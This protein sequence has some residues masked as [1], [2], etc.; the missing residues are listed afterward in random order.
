MIEA[1]SKDLKMR[2]RRLTYGIQKKI[3]LSNLLSCIIPTAAIGIIVLSIAGT[4]MREQLYIN[5]QSF[6]Q[7]LYNTIDNNFYEVFTS[8]YKFTR[9][10]DVNSFIYNDYL[11]VFDKIVSNG[12]LL[13][14]MTDFQTLKSDSDVVL[15]SGT[16][17]IKS[18]DKINI[19]SIDEIKNC[20][21]FEKLR[22]SKDY[23]DLIWNFPTGTANGMYAFAKL[24]NVPGSD[25]PGVVAIGQSYKYFDDILENT[26]FSSSFDAIIIFDGD[27]SIVYSSEKNEGIL[28]DLA[29]KGMD[30]IKQS[31]DKHRQLII[32]DEKYISIL[33]TSPKYKWSIL[34]LTSEKKVSGRLNNVNKYILLITAAFVVIVFVLSFYI[35]GKLSKPIKR[36]T[37]LMKTAEENQYNLRI[38]ENGN[39]EI[40]DLADSF[41]SM[42][43]EFI[44]KQILTRDAEIRALQ[45]QVNPHFL[46]NTLSLITAYANI[47]GVKEISAVCMNLSDIFRYTVN[48]DRMSTV[49]EEV[50]F[51]KKYIEIYKIQNP[52]QFEAE[53][54][55]EPDVSNYSLEKLILQPIVSRDE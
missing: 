42:V 26:N 5:M 27:G 50:A 28:K 18:I 49:G 33:M 31:S 51:V 32:G 54:L 45:H 2:L 29:G 43:K 23:S 30:D 41:N 15:F 21:W 6:T 55:I 40:G 7:Q 38:E 47:R 17:N 13:K 34:S 25:E 16:G 22:M 37:S 11:D 1:K 9:D 35:S 39:D 24:Y 19:S 48:D 8:F 4:Y 53:Y 44:K 46:Y 52:D 12:D 10:K 3:F 14:R 36:L 20:D